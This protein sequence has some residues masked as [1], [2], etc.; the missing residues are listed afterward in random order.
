MKRA[1]IYIS[2]CFVLSMS[3]C[4]V[5][6]DN[7]SNTDISEAT[8]VFSSDYVNENT[9]ANNVEQNAELQ[10][11]GTVSFIVNNTG[12]APTITQTNLNGEIDNSNL[13]VE[14]IKVVGESQTTIYTG[15]LSGYDDGNWV[16]VDFSKIGFLVL[17]EWDSMEDEAI[18]IIPIE[19]TVDNI[20]SGITDNI[21][22]D[23]SSITKI[24][25]T[26]EEETDEVYPLTGISNLS[27]STDE[28]QVETSF[29]QIGQTL[30]ASYSLKN[31]NGN[32]M[33]VK[34]IAASY[35]NG[36]L[37]QI[38]TNTRTMYGFGDWNPTLEIPMPEDSNGFS[39]KLMV[40]NSDTLS[41]YCGVVEL[42]D[43][44][45][46]GNN[47]MFA[48]TPIPAVSGST[49]VFRPKKNGIYTF[50]ETG[51]ISIHLL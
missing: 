29:T 15:A 1:A 36:K 13:N 17:F 49:Y 22:T 27:G 5:K 51:N 38:V 35:L 37:L 23:I 12:D 19:E 10:E 28:L 48:N 3:V 18:Y 24:T 44:P 25:N 16:F 41:P 43:T 30:R 42:T 39:V 21:D 46:I 9:S 32:S 2:I 14:V 4:N 31:K 50:S 11:T 8:E 20:Q 6:A 26:L 40:W 33:N 47:E 45:P 7:T 34:A